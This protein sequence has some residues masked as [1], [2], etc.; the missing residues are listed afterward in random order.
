MTFQ[1][2]RARTPRLPPAG[3]MPDPSETNLERYWNGS[4]WTPRTRDRYTRIE[5]GVVPPKYTASSYY[6][7]GSTQRIKPPRRRSRGVI[8]TLAILLVV[9][10]CYLYVSRAGA[11]PAVEQIA[12]AVSNAAKPTSADVDYPVF[13]STE[14][15][16]HLERGMI[17]QQ[18]SIDVTYWVRVDGIDAVKDAMSE[19]SIQNPYVYA[20]GWTLVGGTGSGSVFVEPDFA[21]D[22]EETLRRQSATRAAVDAGVAESGALAASTDA[23]KVLLIHDYIVSV[24]TY[25]YTAFE[26][27]TSGKD[28]D[29]AQQSQ[30][31][32][33]LLVEG[34][35]VC[36]GYA[37]S[38]NAMA[39]AVGLRSVE[40]T[41][42]DSAGLTGGSHAWNKVLVESRWLLVDTT[43][44]DSND[45]LQ[46]DYLM[47]E[48]NAPI[49]ATRTQNADWVVDANLGAFAS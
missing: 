4:R 34:T 9:A 38:F 10:T 1:P 35:S 7:S 5:T 41:G 39:Q 26:E 6:S 29:R 13:G 16:N 25:D 14:L 44:D 43:W 32:Y 49:L 2:S 19:A 33:G 28:S 27:I 21:H 47:L 3:W 45:E 48:D 24:G 22:T 23:N 46:H 17:A 15:V 42:S 30:E 12:S 40:V 36:N 11:L 20:L 18:T 8:L 31:A 37:Q